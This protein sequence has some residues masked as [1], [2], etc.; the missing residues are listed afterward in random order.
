M[1]GSW[2][3]S[4]QSSLT[5]PTGATSGPRI[6]IDGDADKIFIYAGGPDPVMTI[7]GARGILTSI[8]STET[9]KDLIIQNGALNL[10]FEDESS[11]WG[12]LLAED[13]GGLL[14]GLQLSSVVDVSTV[15]TDASRLRMFPGQPA[16][17]T[18]G[19][20]V[21]R[22]QLQDSF[23]NSDVDW[24]QTGNT[25]RMDHS[26]NPYTWQTVGAA[27]AA[28]YGTGWAASTTFNGS[29][30]WE[31]LRYRLLP[32][33]EVWVLGCFKTTAAAA[34]AILNFSGVYRPKKQTPLTCESVV[35]ATSVKSN[36]AL[37]VGSSGNLNVV[38]AT[39]GST[40]TGQEF[41][42]NAVFPLDNVA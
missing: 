42:I 38:A 26:G 9:H 1:A 11:N 32:T 12:W 3:N 34:A 24:W 19:A 29:T 33:D 2:S 15:Y 13:G 36:F 27:G 39:G 5:I 30:N 7:G 18:G 22:V 17:A 25:V 6:V 31:P 4:Y 16:T 20:G 40:A 8:D 41:L 35:T 28:A 21:P 37:A 23:G 10:G 14:A